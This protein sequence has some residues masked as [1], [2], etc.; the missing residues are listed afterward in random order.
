MAPEDWFFQEPDS[1]IF[2]LSVA[3]VYNAFPDSCIWGWKTREH[4]FNDDAVHIFKPAMPDSGDVYEIGEPL[5]F[6]WDMAFEL[7]TIEPG[8]NY[9]FGDA[10]DPSF[11]TFLVSN[12][13]YH[14]IEPGV[15]LGKR[16]DADPDGQPDPNARGDDNDGSNDDDG[17]V[18]LTPLKAGEQAKVLVTPSVEGILNVWID[19]NGDGFWDGPEEHVFIDEWL[20][21]GTI[22]MTFNVPD[23]AVSK[24]NFA[25]F[26]FSTLSPRSFKGLAI[27]GEVED[28]R[29]N[30]IELG[31]QDKEN[32]VPTEFALLNNYPNPF[33]P[34]TVIRYN[35]PKPVPVKLTIYNLLGNEVRVLVDDSQEPGEY[36]AVWDGLDKY[37]RKVSTGIYIY[38]IKAGDFTQ[39]KKLL[40]LK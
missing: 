15:Y 6:L 36:K 40:L 12:G 3:A 23:F 4:Y 33:N 34:T 22:D 24:D 8:E 35:L 14:I 16:V 37:G 32:R 19:Y 30:I 5:P 26:R 31:V 2:W 28:Y 1:T 10:P 39:A 11:P 29:V 27:D 13:A 21:A 9:D 17:V 7:F 18:F 38:Y 20:P 25:R